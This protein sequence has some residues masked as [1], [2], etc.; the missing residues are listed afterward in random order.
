MS[1]LDAITNSK[2]QAKRSCGRMIDYGSEIE[3]ELTE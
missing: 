3:D 1:E 2:I